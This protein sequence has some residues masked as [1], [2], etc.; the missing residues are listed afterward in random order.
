MPGILFY[1]QTC[2]KNVHQSHI[3]KIQV[4]LSCAFTDIAMKVLD[5]CVAFDPNTETY[6]FAYE[7]VGEFSYPPSF[8]DAK[9]EETDDTSSDSESEDT[10]GVLFN[11]R[12]DDE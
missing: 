9:F 8:D 1:A 10:D 3:L 5:K 11:T 7:Y 4:A 2:C 12:A 6:T